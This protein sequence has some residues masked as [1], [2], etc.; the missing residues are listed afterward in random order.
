MT[1][2]TQAGASATN[3]APT[4]GYARG[5]TKSLWGQDPVSSD[6]HA[7]L[8]SDVALTG[9]TEYFLYFDH[10]F[11]FEDDRL[12][13]N[14]SAYDGG[15]LEY[16]TNGG[17]WTDASALFH[18]GRNYNG[19]ASSGSAIAGRS[20]F[21]YDS[22]GYVSSRY[23]LTSK[24][25]MNI[26]FRWRIATD[27]SV[28]DLGWLLDNV[29]VYKCVSSGVTPSN[30]PTNTPTRTNTPTPTNTTTGPTNTFTPTNTATK[31]NTPTAT[32][33]KTNTPTPSNTPTPTATSGTCGT[34]PTPTLISPASG[35]WTNDLTPTFT[36]SAVSGATAYN[37]QVYNR[38]T[39]T[40]VI[41]ITTTSTTY[42]PSTNLAVADYYWRVGVRNCANVW[43]SY[44]LWRTFY[45]Y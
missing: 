7:R 13:N 33:T 16:R 5:G 6:T 23:T 14:T 32:A 27:S 21:V 8:T 15:V 26:N 34:L 41:N 28:Q 44:T 24:A 4:E 17:A 31:T 42:T 35:A 37:I 11:G 10:A 29:R 43:G 9:G 39:S 25:G 22:H 45:T 2:Q 38:W 36:W 20:A 3:W 1:Y 19:T 40:T 12:A 18:S 30:T